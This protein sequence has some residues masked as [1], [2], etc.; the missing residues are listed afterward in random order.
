MNANFVLLIE[1]LVSL[2]SSLA[3]LY[4]LS[5]P[6]LRTLERICP[7][8]QAANFWL[9]YTRIML[10]IAPLIL[11]LIADLFGRIGDPSTAIRIALLASLAGLVIG[12]RKVGARIEAFIGSPVPTG[13]EK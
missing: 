7:D 6:M 5:P 3:V 12:L 8:E 4:V 11:V 2:I 10:V 9:G 1:I 13:G